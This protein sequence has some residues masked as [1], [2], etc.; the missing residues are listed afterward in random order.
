M[1]DPLFSKDTK[2]DKQNV[3][4]G[5]PDQYATPKYRPAGKGYLIGLSRD[6]RLSKPSDREEQFLSHGPETGQRSRHRSMLSA[7]DSK[8]EYLLAPT[9]EDSVDGIR[10]QLDYVSVGSGRA[11]KRRRVGQD[12]APMAAGI[13]GDDDV[14]SSSAEEGVT[15]S[16]GG[17]DDAYQSFRN[18]PIQARQRSLRNQTL[19]DSN[20]VEA[21]LALVDLQEKLV[22]EQNGVQSKGS[23]QRRLISN[24]RLSIFEDALSKVEHRS[25]RM[26]LTEAF[27][28]EGAKVW[29]RDKQRLEWQGLLKSDQSFELR[30]LY[31]NFVQSSVPHFTIEKVVEAFQEAMEA[32][33]KEA[34]EQEQDVER[35]YLVLRLTLF[36]HQSGFT[37][38]AVALWQALLEFNFFRSPSLQPGEEISMFE[39]FWDSEVARI[40]EPGANAWSGQP[41][42]MERGQD[43]EPPSIDE[44]NSLNSWCAAEQNMSAQNCLPARTSDITDDTDPYRVILFQD[45]KHFMFKLNLETSKTHLLNAFLCYFSLPTIASESSSIEWLSDSFLCVPGRLSSVE[46]PFSGVASSLSLCEPT[47]SIFS[48]FAITV[49]T[50]NLSDAYKSFTSRTLQLLALA[51]VKNTRLGEFAIAYE[52]HQDLPSARKLAKKLLKQSPNGYRLYNAYALLEARLGNFDAAEN[53]W[54]TTLTSQKNNSGVMKLLP[55][56]VCLWHSWTWSCILR[57]DRQRAQNVLQKIDR[58]KISTVSGSSITGG[59]EVSHSDALGPALRQA[60][61]DTLEKARASR[62]TEVMIVMF[63]LLAVCEYLNHDQDLLGAIESYN[64]SFPLLAIIGQGSTAS[65]ASPYAVELLHQQRAHLIDCHVRARAKPFKPRMILDALQD[66]LK[67]FPNNSIFLAMFHTYRQRYGL[68]DRLRETPSSNRSSENL[69][70]YVAS[71]QNEI[72]RPEYA[73]RTEHSIRAAFLNAEEEDSPARTCPAIRLFHVQWEISLL[74][75]SKPTLSVDRRNNDKRIGKASANALNALYSALQTC[76]W[77]KDLYLSALSSQ[78]LQNALEPSGTRSLYNLM[79]D[80]GI[81]LHIDISDQLDAQQA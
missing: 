25:G 43:S 74:Q 19:Q 3:I 50:P 31:I 20:D 39:E 64:S 1:S 10:S 57:E 33:N 22:A 78:L 75:S 42:E 2:G 70:Q 15:E 53:I 9:A 58:S 59:R 6:H 13:F 23:S 35:T 55:E 14:S 66:S 73:G 5:R 80:R 17:V 8:E 26:R 62:N 56:N 49:T 29:D 30:K 67:A 34:N 51:H 41:H 18:D 38:R 12:P 32:T 16:G 72:Q 45:I 36:L 40:G 60:M 46:S 28:K 4:Y 24:L 48:A 61:E 47:G 52:A 65:Y 27:M 71:I 81:R 54:A 7:I 69:L 77:H 37:E 11:R 44:R 68:I 76:P 63:D 79:L 21:W